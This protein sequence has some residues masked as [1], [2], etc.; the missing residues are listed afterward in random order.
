MKT[1]AIFSA[2]NARNLSHPSTL[3]RI[4]GAMLRAKNASK[5]AG[6]YGIG[7]ASI[8]NAK[9]ADY[10]RVFHDRKK[11]GFS[12]TCARTGTDC[13]II[14]LDTLRA[15]NIRAD[16]MPLLDQSEKTVRINTWASCTRKNN[17]QKTVNSLG[18]ISFLQSQ[19]GNTRVSFLALM[20]VFA[21]LFVNV[22]QSLTID[23][24]ETKQRVMQ[25]QYEWMHDTLHSECASYCDG[26]DQ[27]LDVIADKTLHGESVETINEVAA[28]IDN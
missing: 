12:F 19:A 21:L 15:D 11:G 4:H 1:Q 22:A 25:A 18:A 23:R 7:S 6:M 3:A 14:V 9:G 24:L 20:L 5:K 10:L 2:I 13:T 8:P 26:I 16:F 28:S 27:M 17:G